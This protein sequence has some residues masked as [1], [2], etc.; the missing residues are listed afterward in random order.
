MNP[1]D[2]DANPGAASCRRGSGHRGADPKACL[3]GA[4]AG[5][6][7][8]APGDLL[9]LIEV[10]NIGLTYDHDLRLP[11]HACAGIPE[12]WPVDLGGRRRLIHD[13]PVGAAYLYV[14]EAI[15]PTTTPLL[16]PGAQRPRVDLSTL[17]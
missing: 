8:P 2:R 6:G 11:R 7:R 16:P 4:G 5:R 12:A 15:D 1:A 13:R 10:A 14:T 17:F 3:R 9:L